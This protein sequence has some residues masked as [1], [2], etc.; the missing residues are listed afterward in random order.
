MQ[1]AVCGGDKASVNP[2]PKERECHLASEYQRA[3]PAQPNIIRLLEVPPSPVGDNHR[4]VYPLASPVKHGASSLAE[5]HLRCC[6]P[7]SRITRGLRRADGAPLPDDNVSSTYGLKSTKHCARK[8]WRCRVYS[9]TA[10]RSVARARRSTRRIKRP[11]SEAANSSWS[12]QFVL[13]EQRRLAL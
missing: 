3:Q 10:D 12:L 7:Y 5:A 6:L 11:R 1:P 13:V 4:A 2:R 8:P 9:K